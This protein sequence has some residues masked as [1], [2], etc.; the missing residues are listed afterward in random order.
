MTRGQHTSKI[1]GLF[2]G[3]HAYFRCHA[4]TLPVLSPCIN[5]TSFQGDE[6]LQAQHSPDL[7]STARVSFKEGTARRFIALTVS[8]TQLSGG[9][10]KTSS[11]MC[12]PFLSQIPLR[13]GLQWPNCAVSHVHCQEKSKLLSHTSWIYQS[14][15]FALQPW[16]KARSLIWVPF[17][18]SCNTYLFSIS[19]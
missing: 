18:Y 10:K 3:P 7:C 4:L 11:Q 19:I 14:L 5:C 8:A 15:L 16:G 13:T 1:L 17:T 2:L 6:Q 9:G 12:F